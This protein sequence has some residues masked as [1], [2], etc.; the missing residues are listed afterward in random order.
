M[1]NRGVIN[2]KMKRQEGQGDSVIEQPVL[3]ESSNSNEDKKV[4][5]LAVV[6]KFRKVATAMRTLRVHGTPRRRTG[7]SAATPI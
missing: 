1:A 6:P 3:E 5:W 4:P 2:A 7:L